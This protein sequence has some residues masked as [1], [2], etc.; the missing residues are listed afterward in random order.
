MA[1]ISVIVPVYKVEP[2]ISRC[3]DSLLAQSYGDFDLILVDDGSPDRCGALCEAYARRDHRIHVLHRE[4]GGLSAARNTGIDWAMENSDAPWLAFVDSDDWVHP[5]YLGALYAAVTKSG[6]LLAA[7]G[8]FPTAGEALPEGE[9]ASFTVLSPDDYY[10]GDWHGGL[11]AVAWNKLYHRQL[12][13]T[14]RYP[15]GKLHEDQFT[16][17]RA[18]YQAGAV[19]VIPARLYAY[20]QN[21][22][23][24][25]AAPWNPGRLDALEAFRQQLA[26]ARETGND[27]L[28]AAVTEAYIYAAFGQL[29]QADRPY[30]GQLRRA[31]RQ[32]LAL[33]RECGCFPGSAATL[34]AYEAAYPVKPLWWLAD[35]W[36]RR[37][38]VWET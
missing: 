14:L 38:C 18:V 30:R 32:G 10:C 3:V 25:M 19:A 11:I 36:M 2:Y 17:Y 13:R 26:F 8:V 12:F 35:K 34:W 37:H 15:Q 27:R 4:N 7:C 16:T 31:L 1:T 23:G 21:S 22:Q 20:Y 6:C 24:I 33:G 29:S 28:L 9:D 5:D